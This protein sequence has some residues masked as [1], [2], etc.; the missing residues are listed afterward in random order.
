VSIRNNSVGINV[1]REINTKVSSR[2]L[3]E[4]EEDWIISIA[5]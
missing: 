1:T 3:N 5:S 4:N 2:A